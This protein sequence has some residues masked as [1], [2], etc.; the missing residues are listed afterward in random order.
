MNAVLKYLTFIGVLAA[1]SYAAATL[2]VSSVLP[3][4][5]KKEKSS[6]GAVP[7]PSLS[8]KPA[9]LL[10]GLQ[11]QAVVDYSAAKNL[12]AAAAADTLKIWQLPNEKAQLDFDTGDDFQVLALKF[13]PAKG[14]LAAGGRTIEGSAG[15]VRLFDMTSGKLILQIDEP[16]PVMSLDLHPG[17]DYLLATARTYL[18]VIAVKDGAAVAL[19]PKESPTSRGYFY[20]G[21]STVL[22]SDSL[23]LFDV[24][25]QKKMGDLDTVPPLLVRKMGDLDTVPPLLVRK[26]GNSSRFVWLTPDGL[27][28]RGA[29]NAVRE[30]VPLPTKGVVAFDVEPNGRW[31]LLLLEDRKLVTFDAASGKITRT[32]SL[33]SSATDVSINPDAASAAVVLASGEIAV[34]DIGGRNAVNTVRFQM[35]NALHAAGE[36]LSLLFERVTR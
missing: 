33:A 2:D 10:S 11:G 1:A 24:N 32:V 29:P 26:I 28:S 15:G 21:G 19:L 5:A 13:I 6:G 31:G 30:F 9:H 14:L 27:A 34:Y 16:E 22:L 35:T 20:G 36:K 18:K 4:G 17:G 8:R 23:A 7:I 3:A 25:T 12:T